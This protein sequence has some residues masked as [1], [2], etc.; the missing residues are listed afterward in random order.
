MKGEERKK[1]FCRCQ[2]SDERA[3][4]LSAGFDYASVYL[5][6]SNTAHH[7][8]FKCFTKKATKKSK[9]TQKT[10][11]TI[12]DQGYNGHY[13]YMILCLNHGK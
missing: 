10:E 3:R 8:N 6:S 9:Q 7:S 11:T 4:C 5:R 1:Y 13:K 2:C 12:H